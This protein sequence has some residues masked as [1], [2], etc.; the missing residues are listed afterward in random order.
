MADSHGEFIWYELLTGDP[1]GAKAFY[2]PLLGWEFKDSG[3]PGMDYQLFSKDGTEVGGMMALTEDMKEHGAHPLWGGYVAVDDVAASVAKAMA[4][5]GS[6]LVEPTDI[7]EV[8]AFAFLADPQG[9]PIYIMQ[10]FD[11]E[12]S[13]SFAKYEPRE[14][15]CAWNELVTADPAAAKAFYTELFGWEK[16][17]EMDMGPM[18]LYEM[19]KVSDYTFGAMMQKPEMMPA[20]LWVYYLRVPSITE[21]AEFVKANGGQVTTEPMQIPGGDYILNG[22][23][24]QGAFFALIGKG[25]EA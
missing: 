24:P 1:A 18:G 4:A 9:A 12:P 21:A 8:G 11:D 23:D 14:G 5:G 20:S 7:P 19:Y 10:P 15:H 2:G 22:M 6:L 3:M 16:D 17:S 13:Q 25:P